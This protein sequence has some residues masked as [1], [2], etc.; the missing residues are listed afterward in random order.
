LKQHKSGTGSVFTKRYNVSEM[1]FFE[2]FDEMKIAKDRE[3]KLKNW[4]SVWK[5]D[6]INE[7]NPDLKT[8]EII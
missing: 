3:K 6:L 1:L 2:S 4:H 7:S 8:L 5:W